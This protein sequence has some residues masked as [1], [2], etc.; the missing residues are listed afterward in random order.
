VLA[1]STWGYCAI[2]PVFSGAGPGFMEVWRHGRCGCAQRGMCPKC[3]HVVNLG[4]NLP[5]LRDGWPL[6]DSG[7]TLGACYF[8]VMCKKRNQSRRFRGFSAAC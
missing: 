4:G 3:G 1:Q 5:V 6:A 8:A 7:I 2:S